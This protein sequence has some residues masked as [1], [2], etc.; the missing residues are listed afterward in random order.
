MIDVKIRYGLISNL[1]NPIVMIGIMLFISTFCKA[2]FAV[3]WN[4]DSREIQNNISYEEKANFCEIITVVLNNSKVFKIN[5]RPLVIQSET[6]LDY[7]LESMISLATN[8]Q[9]DNRSNQKPIRSFLER[10]KT[11]AA[12]WKYVHDKLP[13]LQKS[14]LADYINSNKKSINISSMPC[15]A[16]AKP[17]IYVSEKKLNPI[18]VK[19][20]WWD[21]F[22]ERYPGSSGIT[23][24]SRPGY[25][26]D[27][28]QA[29][30]YVSRTS[31]GLSGS[32]YLVLF[33]FQDGK[34]VIV[35]EF[36]QWIS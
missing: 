9:K 2:S 3:G 13:D 19:G 12:Y 33:E 16:I 11:F 34:W 22:Y 31:G 32:G 27:K 25:S 6:V 29:L 10:E 4:L 14:T 28:R 8:T 15:Q 36:Q 5:P 20:G 21:E 35:E 30:I 7:H 1:T 24:L 23:E 26:A 17:A 18:F